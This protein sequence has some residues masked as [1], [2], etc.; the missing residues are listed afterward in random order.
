M[1]HTAAAAVLAAGLGILAV[2]LGG[3]ALWQTA[4]LKK[5]RREMDGGQAG[6]ETAAAGGGKRYAPASAPGRAAG[7][8]ES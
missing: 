8:A 7:R 6:R 2:L 1:E 3:A 4:R 5:L